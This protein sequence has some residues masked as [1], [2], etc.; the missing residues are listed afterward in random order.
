M[1]DAI[2]HENGRYRLNPKVIDWSDI[3]AFEEQIDAAAT[4]PPREAIDRMEEARRLYGGDLLDD[5]PFYG[6][7]V[8]VEEHRAVLRQQFEDL[9]VALG[10]AH[11]ELGDG[12]AAAARYRE[13]LSINPDNERALAA[14]NR[15][16]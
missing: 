7:S 13:A 9:L 4:L 5:C 15:L 11:A 12:G 8:Y 1:R 3:D 10:D 2:T 16:G 6:D 14:I